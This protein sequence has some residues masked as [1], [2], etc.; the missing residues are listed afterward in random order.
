MTALLCMHFRL[1]SVKHIH[2]CVCDASWISR[3]RFAKRLLLRQITASTRTAPG[4]SFS[5]GKVPGQIV[6][7]AAT[8]L[9]PM[10]APLTTVAMAQM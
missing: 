9:A 7:R 1:N 8:T 3:V 5:L 4:K 10:N 6:R 2:T